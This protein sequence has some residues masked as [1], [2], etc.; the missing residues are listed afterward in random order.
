MRRWFS[1]ANVMATVAVFIALGGSSYAALRIGSGQIADNSIRS[2][3]I[4]DN[5]LRGKDVRDRSLLAKDFRTGQ[6]PPGPAGRTGPAGP[7]GPQ[8]PA[9]PSTGPAGGDLSGTYPD[10]TIAAGA[11]TGGSGG[12]VADNSLTGDDVLE[13]SLGKVTDADALDGKDSTVFTERRWAV[14]RADGSLAR[15]AGGATSARSVMGVYFINFPGDATGCAFTTTLGHD[16]NNT[17]DD[18]PGFV[19]VRNG[20]ANDVVVFTYNSAG[21]A[22]DRGFH[23]T[24][25]C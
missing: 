10:P 12:K 7:T 21:G 3:D 23:L 22:T 13:S 18:S 25:N 19:T 4:R 17:P 14:V 20:S 15:G 11:V 5:Q 2:K 1:Y 24:V 16:T 9:G 8:G 6:I